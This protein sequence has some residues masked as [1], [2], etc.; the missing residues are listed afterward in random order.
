[1]ALLATLYIDRIFLIPSMQELK[2]NL[3]A[4]MVFGPYMLSLFFIWSLSKGHRYEIISKE[5][6]NALDDTKEILNE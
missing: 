1:M 2:Y 6:N 4:W 3:I 5:E